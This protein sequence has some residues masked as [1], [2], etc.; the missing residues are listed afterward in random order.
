MTITLKML[1]L[2][3]AC[4]DQVKLFK[5]T[6][7]ESVFVTRE[8]CEK[9]ASLFD[10]KWT[11]LSFLSASAWVE[12]EEARASALAEYEKARASAWAEYEEVC[13]SAWAEYR[14]VSAT[15]FYDAAL[16]DAE[17]SPGGKEEAK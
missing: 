7:G 13:A 10:F 15:A 16:L 4:K 6:F 1:R 8:L 12:Y 14:K 17:L 11:A 3:G 5:D 2:K 9:F